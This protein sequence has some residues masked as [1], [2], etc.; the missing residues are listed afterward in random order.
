MIVVT[1]EEPIMAN[2]SVSAS[3]IINGVLGASLDGT[4]TS[5]AVLTRPTRLVRDSNTEPAKFVPGIEVVKQEINYE[6]VRNIRTG[7]CFGIR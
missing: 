2:V 6:Q 4:S 1:I 3:D 5:S 7:L